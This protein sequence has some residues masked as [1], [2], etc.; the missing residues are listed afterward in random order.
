MPRPRYDRLP[1]ERRTALLDAAAQEFAEH[2]YEAASFNRILERSGVSKG[3]AYYYFDDKEDLFLTVVR[4]YMDSLDLGGFLSVAETIT[5][6]QFWPA[7]AE[8]YR[9]AFVRS[10]DI[11]WAFGVWRAGSEAWRSERSGPLA[12]FINEWMEA[13]LRLFKRGQ[14]LGV[15]R[16]DL[17]DDLLLAWV[18]AVDDAHDRW[19]L[20]HWHE[21]DRDALSAAAERM[22]DGLRRL[23]GNAGGSQ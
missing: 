14:E 6:E 5:A 3:A 21:L 18:R 22:V 9:L 23:V 12:D 13:A 15:I 2:G 16:T 7:I 10:H 19:V 17:P 4:H 8:I 20:D 1:P 11:P